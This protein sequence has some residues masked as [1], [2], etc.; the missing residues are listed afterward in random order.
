LNSDFHTAPKSCSQFV[1]RMLAASMLCVLLCCMLFA[2][3]ACSKKSQ[4]G[5][6]F[7]ANAKQE[8]KKP[9]NHDREPQSQASVIHFHHARQRWELSKAIFFLFFHMQQN[10][11]IFLQILKSVFR[12][13]NFP[14]PF[15]PPFPP[16]ISPFNYNVRSLEYNIH[17]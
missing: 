2:Y 9:R 12:C 4:T 7:L 16:P 10:P 8:P 1:F 11:C 6:P 3:H 13:R 5:H 14:P 17:V 15:S